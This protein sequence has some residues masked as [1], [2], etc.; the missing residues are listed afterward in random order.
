M[1]EH[2]GFYPIRRKCQ[3][4]ATKLFGYSFMTRVFS[5]IILKRRINLKNPRDLNEKLNWLKLNR[6]AADPLVIQCADKFA[7]REYV[8][9]NIGAEYLVP[10]Y[11]I[12]NSTSDIAWTALPQSFV[13]KCNHGCGYNILIDDKRKMDLTQIK[14]QLN[15]WLHEDF[16][17]FNAE[18][19][20]HLIPRKIISEKHLGHNL[21]D[22]KFLLH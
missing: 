5:L 20:Y 3:A 1:R 6:Y 22:Y 13:L 17:L 16:S 7:V 2:S 15:R 14:K 18:N 19:Q 8:C 21:R 11:G 12:W 10:L 4:L 9:K